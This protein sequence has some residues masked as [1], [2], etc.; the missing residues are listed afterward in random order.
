MLEMILRRKGFH[1]E[2]CA[3]GTE[4]LGIIDQKGLE[5][6][7]VIFM[8]SLMPIMVSSSLFFTFLS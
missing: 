1:C 3:D 5:A 7:D 6:F 4:V 2:Q 8:D